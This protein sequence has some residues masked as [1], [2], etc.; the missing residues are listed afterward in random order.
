[1]IPTSLKAE[2]ATYH[3]HNEASSTSGLLQLK[4][5]GPDVASLTL[6]SANLKNAAVG[7]YLIKAFDTQ[8]GVPNASGVIPSGS[9]LSFTLWMK[10]SASNNAG[11]MFPRAKVY[12]N[13]A[14]GTFLCTATGTSALTTT[15]T[16]Y[17]LT[18]DTTAN[19]TLTG[20]D[21]F[22]L[23][24]GV[25]I[26]VKATANV[27][28]QLNIEGT[29]NGN[30][31]SRI[32]VPLPNPPATL[33][34]NKSGT[35]DGTVT[36]SPAGIDCGATCFSSFPWG[37][38]V[39]L[40][41]S[42]AGGSTAA[43]FSGGC[44]S[45]TTTCVF[46][47]T[48]GTTVTAI[49]D[50]EFGSISGKVTQ[51]DGT[52]PISG[53]A[54]ELFEGSVAKGV[55]STDGSGDYTFENLSSGTY[56]VQASSAGYVT[57][58]ATG[59]SVSSG[60]TTV[61]FSLATVPP[62]NAIQYV[63]DE[64]NRLVGAIDPAGETATYHYDAVG[65]LLSISRQ[66]SSQVSIIEFT[67]ISGLVGTTVTLYGTG[68]SATASENSVT[69]NGTAAAV[70][71]STATQIVT[72]VPAGATTGPIAV[73]TPSG[74]ATSS[75]PFTVSSSTAPTISGFTPTAGTSGTTVTITGTNFDTIPGN[76]KV[77]F[78][79]KYS[80]VSSS[81][82]TTITT[83]V[84]ANATSGRISVATPHGSA[85]STDDF[86]SPPA[87][88]VPADVQVT[89]RMVIG[90]TKNVAITTANK[91]ALVLFDG[92]AGQKISLGMSG[93]TIPASYVTIY[94]PNGTGLATTTGGVG[95]SGAFIDTQ[96][97]LAT[98]TYTILVDPSLT[99]TGNMTLTLYEV[100]ADLTGTIVPGGS[101]VPVTIGTPGQ[102]ARLTFSGTAGQRV[103]LNM[104]SITISVS[105]VYIY[106]PDGSTLTSMSV[107]IPPYSAFIEPQTLPATGT[108][109][110]FMSPTSNLTGSMTLTLYEVQ[111]VTGTITIGGSAAQVTIS[112]PGQTGSLT[113]SGTS[114][115]QVTVH[116][117]N[118]TMS[119]V[120]VKL[121]KPD[122]STLTSS[123]SSSS[124]FNL[125]TQTLPTTDTYTIT[126]DPSGANTG[127]M[128]VSVTSP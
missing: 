47:I 65:N 109:T 74:S 49:F 20:S 44:T 69:F 79:T 25:N 35:G 83:N 114:G 77:T 57:Q 85:V 38:S 33:T 60:E 58:N 113:F 97:L 110:I 116:V 10:K 120:T 61:N 67:P 31:D 9:T 17:T 41:A 27:T 19:V 59:V 45:V 26:T 104:T 30:Y 54:V 84:P 118:N 115:Q 103:S 89:D 63:Y 71:S 6:S 76:N 53:A 14:S 70:S 100:P 92:T 29:L 3:L 11:T 86:I 62:G 88:Y 90:G 75:A 48:T 24:V 56:T 32:T 125:N 107:G 40:T 121:L 80:V 108:Y 8:A 23:W 98:G 36:S 28:A 52:T 22:Y 96:T 2:T 73:T 112:V 64:L 127:S 105:S 21:R 123:T 87:P 72:I 81:T 95:T 82:A 18:C 93:V 34:L 39:T 117:T 55:A 5:A 106:K 46:T 7:E 102:N 91:V 43:G 128:N 94:N 16:S 122:G 12:L 4:T 15:V 126:I 124:S 99:Y 37:T 119:T 42:A 13:N 68:F 50:I 78:N 111:D 66:S 51:S 101:S 1:M